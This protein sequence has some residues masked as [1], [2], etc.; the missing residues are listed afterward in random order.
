MNKAIEVAKKGVLADEI[1]IGAVLVNNHNNEII[2]IAHNKINQLSNSTKHAE[3]I[4]IEDSCV[5]VL[6]NSNLSSPTSFF[7]TIH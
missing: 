4:V 1:P 5:N 7:A 2:S 6:N 3:M